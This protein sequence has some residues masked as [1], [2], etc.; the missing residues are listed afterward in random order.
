MSLANVLLQTGYAVVIGLLLG[1]VYLKS[2]DIVS[3]VLAHGCID[4]S[5]QIFA[6][7]SETTSLPFVTAFLV[8]L[9][10][11]TCYAFWLIPGADKISS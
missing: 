4:V 5:Y 11:L 2:G 6:A 9:L 1:A 7:H 3:V 10:A 8:I